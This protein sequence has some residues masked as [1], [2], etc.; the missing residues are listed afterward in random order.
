MKITNIQVD[1]PAL[2]GYVNAPHCIV[3]VDA[4]PVPTA[5][6]KTGL[7]TPQLYTAETG[8]F[9]LHYHGPLIRYSFKENR[10]GKTWSSRAGAVNSTLQLAKPLVDVYLKVEGLN[11]TQAGWAM[12]LQRIRRELKKFSPDWHLVVDDRL[13]QAGD[14]AW[15]PAELIAGCLWRGK[16]SLAAAGDPPPCGK[17][18]YHPFMN[19]PL[20]LCD[21]HKIEHDAHAARARAERIRKYP[22]TAG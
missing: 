16:F 14:I 3:T 22:S 2:R 20:G 17:A 18:A 12:E 10:T 9:S 6:H 11:Y 1:D 19:R 5:D 8:T 7:T 4:E 13:A 21:E 15:S